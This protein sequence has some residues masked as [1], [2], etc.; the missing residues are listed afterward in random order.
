[1]DKFEITKEELGNLPQGAYTGKIVVID[2]WD[3]FQQA[4]PDIK[5]ETLLGVDCEIKP[6]FTKGITYPVSLIQIATKDC[7]FL[8]RI[9]KTGFP[10][11]IIQILEN[12][13]I[14]KAGIDLNL[15]M[16]NLKKIKEFEPQN[17]V[18]LN[19]LAKSKGYISTGAKKLTALI[20]GFRISKR[21]Q[22]SNWEADPL[23]E[24]QI[25]YAATDAWIAREL[26]LKLWNKE[27]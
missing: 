1:M 7:V 26:Y 2:E 9:N 12:P 14:I 17:I 8:I 19:K 21:M 13:M 15:D 20:L 3:G 4:I 16:T 22:T 25:R 23:N 24:K 27:A 5:K 11:Q 6:A 18:D 10:P